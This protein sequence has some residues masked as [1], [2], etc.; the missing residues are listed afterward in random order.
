MTIEKNDPTTYRDDGINCPA[1]TSEITHSVCVF[2]SLENF[3]FITNLGTF[4]DESGARYK[5]WDAPTTRFGYQIFIPA[6]DS[7]WG[8]KK[9]GPREP[10]GERL[11]DRIVKLLGPK[12]ESEDDIVP[13][14]PVE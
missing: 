11:N 14:G 3:R 13:L 8:G 9:P 2:G 5:R 1:V 7:T 6:D 10:F 12:Y 4:I